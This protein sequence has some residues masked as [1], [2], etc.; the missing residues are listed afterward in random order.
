M[1]LAVGKT[2][3]VINVVGFAVETVTLGVS[4]VLLL[5]SV[6]E[7]LEFATASCVVRFAG[8]VQPAMAIAIV[9]NIAKHFVRFFMVFCPL[10]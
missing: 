5:L 6:A 9:M 8:V 1:L 4:T 3:S 7:R 2:S 10:Y